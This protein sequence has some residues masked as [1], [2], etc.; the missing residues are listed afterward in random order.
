MVTLRL[1]LARPSSIPTKTQL[2]HSLSIIAIGSLDPQRSGRRAGSSAHASPPHAGQVLMPLTQFHPL[3]EQRARTD[4]PAA[5][6]AARQ[7]SSAAAIVF[8]CPYGLRSNH[9]TES[10]RVPEFHRRV[11]LRPFALYRFRIQQENRVSCCKGTH[12]L[13]TVSPLAC[14][15]AATVFC[16]LHH[17]QNDDDRPVA[18]DSSVASLSPVPFSNTCR[19]S[20]PR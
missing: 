1:Q 12:G 10:D 5:S 15:H 20:T 3:L 14:S 16:C 7:C 18:R 4:C 19:W 2:A 17:P 6:A 11:L 9:G 13:G 8:K